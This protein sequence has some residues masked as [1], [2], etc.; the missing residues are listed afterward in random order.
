M[1]KQYNRSSSF[2]SAIERIDGSKTDGDRTTNYI[3]KLTKKYKVNGLSVSIFNDFDIVYKKAF[4][5]KHKN[6]KQ[7]LNTQTVFYGA[8][9]SKPV[10]SALVLK[11]VDEGKLELDYPLI[12]YFPEKKLRKRKLWW[13]EYSVLNK[14]PR[15]RN[16]TA[17]MCLSHT[18]GL[19]NWRWHESNDYLKLKF[20]PGSRYG[21]SGEGFCFLQLAIETITGASL[22]QL[23][24]KIIFEPIEMKNSGFNWQKKFLINSCK[25]HDKKNAVFS[26]DTDSQQ[27]AASTLV[28]TTDDYILFLKS[29]L[30]RD[31]LSKNSFQEMFEKQIGINSEKQLG[32]AAARESSNY[33]Y[34]DLR[35]GLGWG[36]FSTPFGKAVF[37]EGHGS[38]FAHY[39]VLFPESGKGM[40]IL[41]NDFKT[42]KIYSKLLENCI[43][44]KFSPVKWLV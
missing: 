32:T 5:H 40:L 29:I 11:L 24:R 34:I 9:L 6:K 43:A 33:N 17:R 20:N 18:S 35:Y 21:Y 13:K 44:D 39:C 14:D 41:S 19:P 4:G 10:F 16:V 36:I 8:S 23:A 30:R 2:S 3:N 37:K 38:G 12:N 31:I 1:K 22:Q 26:L 7:L 28:T 15:I 42:E 25:G 27:R